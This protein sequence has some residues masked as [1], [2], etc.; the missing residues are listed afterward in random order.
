[1]PIKARYKA[2]S[3]SES[4]LLEDH[5]KEVAD[6]AA[7]FAEK[8]KLSELA[9]LVA[10]VHDLGKNSRIWQGYLEE[11]HKTG[12]K[13]KKEDHGTA[14]GQYLYE[15]LTQNGEAGSELIAQMIAACAMYHHGPALPDVISPDG[16]AQLSLRLEKSDGESHAREAAANLGARTKERIDAILDDKNF[17]ARTMETVGALAKAE[18]DDAPRFYMG[19]TAR[20]LSSCLIDADRRSSA[21]FDKG[22][23]V[24]IEDAVKKADWKAL[25]DKLERHLASLP[26][27][28]WLNEVRREISDLCVELAKR[29]NGIYTLSA[30]TGGGKTLAALR[31]ALALAELSGKERI[32][33]IA[34]YTSI[35]DQTADTIR[36]ILDPGGKNGELILEHHSN[37]DAGEK[38]ERF[39][40]ATETWN[41]PIVITTMVQFLEALFGAGTRK[42]RRMHQ[43]AN[44]VIII[45]EAQTLPAS[46]TY[47]FNWAIQYL[48][49]NANVSALLCTATQPGLDKLDEE[50]KLPL[51]ADNEVIPD[52]TRHFEALRR[53]DLINKTKSGGWTLDEVAE[54]IESSEEKSVLTVVNT[55]AQ[56][57]KLYEKVAKK[58]PDWNVVHLSANM[59]PAHRRKIITQLKIDLKN[60][61]KKCICISTRLIE[62]GVDLDF[63]SAIRFLAGFDSI[64]QTIGRCNRHGE[65]KDVNGNPRKGKAYIVD[66]VKNEEEIKSLP[67]LILGQ[68]IMRRILRE[69]NEDKEDF[70][71]NLMHPDLIANYFIYYYK[72]LPASLLKY[73]IPGRDATVLELLSANGTG[74]EEYYESK[75][76][77]DRKAQPQE[78]FGQSFESAWSAFEVIAQNTIGVIVPFERG[79][80]IIDELYGLPDMERCLEL[81]KEAQQYSLNVFPQAKDE[82]LKSKILHIVPYKNGMEIYTLDERHYDQNIGLTNTDGKMTFLNT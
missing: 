42:V 74:W 82:M 54:F 11:N 13:N 10:L 3:E 77:K 76:R 29:G 55:K 31:Y 80:E 35:I 48:C 68:G 69:F 47:L 28:G 9:I 78:L 81:L 19:L 40:E 59:C 46:C 18:G 63:D 39:D 50:Y 65:L 12:R 4:Q 51:T 30:A 37:L 21:M 71:G 44:S 49:Q 36:G 45:D 25:L 58:H 75:A 41:A 24:K 14:G 43:L 2:N 17:I 73:K 61:T 6:Y 22:I 53:V 27:E 32:F 33:I 1:M 26:A 60:K 23:P 56:A 64:I 16:T 66:I 20:F 57:R 8:I 5:A 52:I 67:E 38:T 70:G 7:L 34:P 15:R 72:A 62:A 79:S